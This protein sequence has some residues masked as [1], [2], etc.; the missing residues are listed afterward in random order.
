MSSN[1]LPLKTKRFPPLNMRLVILKTQLPWLHSLN[2]GFWWYIGD[3]NPWTDLFPRYALKH[4]SFPEAFGKTKLSKFMHFQV[5][6]ECPSGTIV[7]ATVK[8]HFFLKSI[9]FFCSSSLFSS[10]S[11][12]CVFFSLFNFVVNLFIEEII[13]FSIQSRKA[14]NETSF[15]FL[16]KIAFK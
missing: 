15:H 9:A 7:L 6:I 4:S 14:N 8:S 12:F 5:W 13:G 2:P 11:Y 3:S 10:S 16:L 1:S